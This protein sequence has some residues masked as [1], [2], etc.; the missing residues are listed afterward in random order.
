MVE[1]ARLEIVWASN[2]LGGSN[3]LASAT[4][5]AGIRKDG[6]F[7]VIFSRL[8]KKCARIGV[9]CGF[10]RVLGIKLGKIRN[11]KLAK[12]GMKDSKSW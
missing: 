11:G 6:L 9:W 7:K 2:R 4:S 12:S 3:P 1:G 10:C 5:L 8:V